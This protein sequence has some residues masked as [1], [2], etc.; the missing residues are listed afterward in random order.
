MAVY[1]ARP[2]NARRIVPL[3]REP[4]LRWTTE[5]TVSDKELEVIVEKFVI[6]K[7][8]IKTKRNQMLVV[9]SET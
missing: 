5:R 9:K 7:M 6:T 2:A 1:R 4:D 3:P 8:T